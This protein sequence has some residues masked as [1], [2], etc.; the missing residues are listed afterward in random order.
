MTQAPGP[1]RTASDRIKHHSQRVLDLFVEAIRR[2]ISEARK[3]SKPILISSLPLLLKHMQEQLL[4]PSKEVSAFKIENA[5]RDHVEQRVQLTDYSLSNVLTEYHLLRKILFEVLREE[6]PLTS[7]ESDIINDVIDHGVVHAGQQYK[8]LSEARLKESQEHFRLLIEGTT[9]YAIFMLSP[10]G[11]I[12]TWNSGAERIKGYKAEEIIG[13]H[14]SIFYP[15]EAI[16][17]GHPE[18][19]LKVAAEFGKYEEEGIRLRKDGSE[20]VANVLITALRDN[21][22]NLK[23]YSKITRDI[24]ESKNA[25]KQFSTLANSISQLAWMAD[26]SGYIFWYNDRW[27]EYTGTTPKQM[28]GWGWQSVHDP[29][30]LSSVLEKWKYSVETGVS[31]DMTFPLRSSTGEF[32]SFLTRVI[33]F[34]DNDGKIINWFGT[35]TDIQA[36]KETERALADAIENAK[37]AI[38]ARDEF[39]SIASHELKTPLT[40]LKLQLQMRG[41]NLSKGDFSG[42]T[43]EKIAKMVEADNRQIDRISRLIDDMLDVTRINTGKLTMEF[44]R[45]DLCGLVEEVLSHYRDQFDSLGL[46]VTLVCFDPVEGYWDRFRIEQA[47]ANLLMNAMKYGG[48]KPVEISVGHK[49][50]RAFL[51]VRDQGIGI[52]KENLER[53]F[54]RFE[55]A[56]VPSEISGLGLGLYITKQ[57]LELHGGGIRVESEAGKGSTFIIELPMTDA[58]LK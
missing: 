43:P 56:V 37:L 20:F 36:Q 18:H 9:D 33:P 2:N 24:T 27:Y 34:R 42:F 19:E 21:N 58:P 46:K 23:G 26:A 6:G 1:N 38:R 5:A 52:A 3:A 50:G 31:F 25:Q 4:D 40:S 16:K 17:I 51:K 30:E 49:S 35:N 8:E 7:L 53:I 22:G 41:R 47:I 11:I 15:N 13:K 39:M 12:E 44:E 45:F 14:F 10:E 29:K 32:R 57:I 54:K 28:E 48:G 55:R